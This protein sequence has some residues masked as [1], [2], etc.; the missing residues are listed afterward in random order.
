[1]MLNRGISSI[2]I[3]ALK[4]TIVKISS[5]AVRSEHLAVAAYALASSARVDRVIFVWYII[6]LAC[7]SRSSPECV[8]L[9]PRSIAF[10]LFRSLLLPVCRVSMLTEFLHQE[11]GH[12]IIRVS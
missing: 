6:P 10:A 12:F 3:R 7:E 8:G 2:V 1:M 5:T 11:V 4:I 9:V